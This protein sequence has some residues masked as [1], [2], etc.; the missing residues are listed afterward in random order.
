[1]TH[2]PIYAGEEHDFILLKVAPPVPLSSCLDGGSFA[3]DAPAD[4]YEIGTAAQEPHG[5]KRK[6]VR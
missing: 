1:M 3:A 5:L 4:V 2:F 6:A